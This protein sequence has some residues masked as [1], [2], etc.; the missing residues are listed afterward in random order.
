MDRIWR[1]K[2]NHDQNKKFQATIRDSHLLCVCGSVHSLL[3]RAVA[4][5]VCGLCVRAAA[6]GRVFSIRAFVPVVRLGCRRPVSSTQTF[7]PRR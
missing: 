4:S 5:A 7:I 2:A 6:F 3:V 1:L